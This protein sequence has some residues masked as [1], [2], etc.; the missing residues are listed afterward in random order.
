VF[1]A[2]K[3]INIPATSEEVQKILDLR[4]LGYQIGSRFEAVNVFGTRPIAAEIEAAVS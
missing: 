4:L 3:M 2:I 1:E